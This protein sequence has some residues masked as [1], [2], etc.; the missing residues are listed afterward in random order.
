MY[1]VAN[2]AVASIIFYCQSVVDKLQRAF[3]AIFRVGCRFHLSLSQ[4]VMFKSGKIA[5]IDRF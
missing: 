1:Y 5:Q 3:S 4:R 2:I